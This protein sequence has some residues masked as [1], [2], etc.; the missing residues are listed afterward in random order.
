MTQVDLLQLAS[1]VS[2]VLAGEFLTTKTSNIVKLIKIQHSKQFL[3][4]QNGKTL[5]VTF[6]YDIHGQV[7]ISLFWGHCMSVQESSAEAWLSGGLLQGWGHSV[8]HVKKQKHYFA[9][10]SLSSQSYG[11]SSSHVQM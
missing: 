1:L 2:P 8:Q 9:N 11:F 7:W 6:I 4:T 3:R 10:K 5:I